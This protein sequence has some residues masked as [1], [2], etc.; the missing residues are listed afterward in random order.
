MKGACFLHHQIFNKA[1]E[2]YFS[3]PRTMVNSPKQPILIGW[4]PPTPG[5]IKL[6]TDGSVSENPGLAIVGSLLRDHNGGWVQGF[7]R[8]INWTNSLAAELWGLRDGLHLTRNLN[9]HKL[10]VEI[11]AKAVV[12]LVESQNELMLNSHGHPYS[13]LISDCRFLLLYFEKV[14]FQHIHL[15]KNFSARYLGK[16]LGHVFNPL[17][18]VFPPPLFFEITL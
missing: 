18:F 8:H 13:N 4:E 3:L 10:L 14:H 9:I 11:D 6:N 15:E 5:F 12:D 17:L 16:G 1:I 7:T 2:F